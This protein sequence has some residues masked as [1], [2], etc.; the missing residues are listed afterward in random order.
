MPIRSREAR[1]GALL[2][3][4]LVAC[5]GASA[6]PRPAPEVVVETT[7]DPMPTVVSPDEAPGRPSVDVATTD[8]DAIAAMPHPRQRS[9]PPTTTVPRRVTMRA[10]WKAKIGLTTFRSTMVF[11]Q[12]RIVVGTHGRSLDGKGESDDGVHVLDARTGKTLRVIPSPGAGD[13][14][15]GGVAVDGEDVYFGTDNGLLVGARLDGKVR[16]TAAIGGKVRPAPALG[17]LNGDGAVEVVV[18]DEQGRLQVYD[19]QTGRR[20]WQKQTGNNLY[21]NRGFIGAAALVD[22]DGDRRLDV[23]AGARDGVLRAYRGRDGQ[24]LWEVERD[25]GMHASPSFGDFDGD[26]KPEVLAAWSYGELGIFDAKTGAQR[27]SQELSLDSGGIEGLFGSPIPLPGR[28]GVLVQGTSWWGGRDGIVGVGA[29]ERAYRS[30]EGRVSS[31]AVVTDLDGDGTMEAILGTETGD[32]VALNPDGERWL[33]WRIGRVEAPA[34]LAD[35]DQNGTFELLVAADDHLHCFET[36]SRSTPFI[37][38]FRGDD[39]HNTGRLGAVR[40]HW[41]PGPAKPA[42]PGSKGQRDD[43]VDCCQALATEANIVPRRH[44]AGFMQASSQCMAMASRGAEKN[45]MLA[46][47][48]NLTQGRPL[49]LV[50]R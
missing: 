44:A 14:D 1:S 3:L 43:Y 27:W 35:V 45:D 28:A 7:P 22:V 34:M 48:R 2:T 20:L 31:T 39:P 49:P 33:L 19:S 32:L 24:T 12:G 42:P 23:V 15:V 29:I 46:T 10:K 6:K 13:R 47:I 9:T 18:G 50:C 4:G 36:D 25:S 17:D 30:T 26:G 8:F 41:S 37:S 40:L 21:G 11:T 5:S 16:W 38:R